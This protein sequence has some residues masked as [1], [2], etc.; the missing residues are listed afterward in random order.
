MIARRPDLPP[1]PSQKSVAW[2]RL[3]TCVVGR[4][5]MHMCRGACLHAHVSLGVSAR[6]CVVGRA[7]MHMCRGACRHAHV[8]LGVP[9]CT[10][11]VGRASMHMCR[12]ACLH[13]H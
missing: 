1:R 10:C 13:A 11:V 3:F 6:T 7:S 5:S 2:S 4:A 9:P 8:S 12:G